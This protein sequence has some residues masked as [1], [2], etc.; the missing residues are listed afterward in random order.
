MKTKFDT[1]LVDYILS[2]HILVNIHTYEKDRCIEEICKISN[3]VLKMPVYTWSLSCGWR[4]SQ[5]QQVNPDREFPS[6]EDALMELKEMPENSIFIMK[7]YQIYLTK[8]TYDKYDII[9]SM[10]YEMQNHLNMN[11]SIILFVGPILSIPEQL[12]YEITLMEFDLPSPERIEI[13]IRSVCENVKTQDGSSF[14]LKEEFLERLVYAC[15]GMTQQ[16]I[17][18]KVSLVLR[19]TKGLETEAID[20]LLSEKCMIIKQSG[21]LSYREN[22]DGD[23]NIVGGYDNIKSHIMI[24]KKCLSKEAREY[25]IDPPKGILLVGV[26]G[27]GKS[28]LCRC[29]AAEFDLPL[30]IFDVG[31][32]MDQFVGNS[33]AKMRS[34]IKLIESV[35]PC[36]VMLDEIEKGF[37]GNSLD[38]GTSKRV[39]GYFLTWLSDRKD[40]VYV[41]ATANNVSNLPIEFC[42]KGRFDEIFGLLLPNASEREQILRIHLEKRNKADILSDT[43]YKQI[44][45]K[46]ENFSGAEIEQL[47]I[48]SM[49]NCFVSNKPM[50]VDTLI[51]TC[52]DI[53][54]LYDFDGDAVRNIINWVKKHAKNSSNEKE[55]NRES[56]KV[57]I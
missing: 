41:V 19:K 36:V 3:D 5:Y 40:S 10:L 57:V 50:C 46:T 7:D 42:R 15:K 18:D 45:M 12:K 34:A 14:K 55:I 29:I 35:S 21:I 32:I 22:K 23:L 4:D 1:E 43:D 49:K 54:T 26:P 2:G 13:L 48:S 25:G 28:L 53:K 8:E 33:E 51:D 39:F 20:L 24:D 9:T 6:A 30:L 16:Q 38:G 27:A 31:S 47:I 37:G 11:N 56:R 52:C 44:A 17:L